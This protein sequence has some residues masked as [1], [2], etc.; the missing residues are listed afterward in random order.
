MTI[1]AN[2]AEV[3]LE[4]ARYATPAPPSRRPS[5]PAGAGASCGVAGSRPTIYQ[6]LKDGR[7][8]VVGIGLCQGHGTNL[9]NMVQ[10]GKAW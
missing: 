10:F 3:R 8:I 4:K 1:S 6:L 2:I 7:P 9:W 5:P